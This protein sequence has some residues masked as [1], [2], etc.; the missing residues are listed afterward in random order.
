MR[1]KRD[2]CPRE[3][4][5]VKAMFIVRPDPSVEIGRKLLNDKQVTARKQAAEIARLRALLK[6]AKIITAALVVGN[7]DRWFNEDL[8]KAIIRFNRKKI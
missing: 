2:N 3:A 5:R 4:G 8:K 6:E 7:Y 1:Q